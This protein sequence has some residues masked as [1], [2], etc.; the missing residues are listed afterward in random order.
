VDPS[1]SNFVHE[2][3]SKPRDAVVALVRRN[4]DPVPNPVTEF[5][6]ADEFTYDVYVYD[7]GAYGTTTYTGVTPSNRRVT[8]VW[9]RPALP[10]DPNNPD[11][12]GS[13]VGITYVGNRVLFSIVEPPY[14]QDCQE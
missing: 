7:D 5:G 11:E 14:F 4:G 13:P 2:S 12:P 3:A 9:V 8:D 1:A 10:T 6:P